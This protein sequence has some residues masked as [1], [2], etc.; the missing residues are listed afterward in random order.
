[1]KRITIAAA[2][3]VVLLAA[4]CSGDGPQHDADA[5]ACDTF[6]TLLDDIESGDVS[7]ADGVERIEAAWE[8]A[9]SDR[10]DDL[11]DDLLIY[12]EDGRGNLDD[13]VSS[14]EDWCG[15]D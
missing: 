4:S 12:F 14:I 7:D 13:T 9:D 11:L 6:A 3:A 8:Q 1:M 10:L 5:D 2:G 15:L